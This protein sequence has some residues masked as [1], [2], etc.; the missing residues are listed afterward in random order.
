MDFLGHV[1]AWMLIGGLVLGVW[2]CISEDSYRMGSSASTEPP[3]PFT[4]GEK[5]GMWAAAIGI[6][7]L[8]IGV[9]GGILSQPHH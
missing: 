8:L 7:F 4:P 9:I 2:Q 6:T 5:T 3:K 1:L